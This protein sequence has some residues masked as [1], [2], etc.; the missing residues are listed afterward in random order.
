M[1]I[2]EALKDEA[3]VLSRIALDAKRHW[4]CPE[5]WI[6]YWSDD[7]T[8]S[9]EFISQ[10]QVFVAEC[11]NEIIGFYALVAAGRH[12]ELEHMWVAPKHIGTGVGKE[13]FI[14]AMQIAAGDNVS[15]V[16]LSADPNA[17]GFYQKMGA[18]RIGEVTSEVMGETRQLP[19]LTIDPTST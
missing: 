6:Q 17:E 3:A 12:A 9:P 4:G 11:E 8:I 18:R 15:E 1:R 5:D 10:N 16:E 7:L 19:R 14:H 2:R 13:L